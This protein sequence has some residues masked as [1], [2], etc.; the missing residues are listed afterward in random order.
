MVTALSHSNKK[1]RLQTHEP[2]RPIQA[3]TKY[4]L[5][6]SPFDVAGAESREP[7]AT[8]YVRTSSKAWRILFD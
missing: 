5:R 8:G 4:V 3:A 6:M 2:M 7:R 1:V